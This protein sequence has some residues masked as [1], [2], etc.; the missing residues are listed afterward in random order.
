MDN[1]KSLIIVLLLVFSSLQLVS[2]HSESD[3]SQNTTETLVVSMPD[4]HTNAQGD[5]TINIEESNS[6][7]TTPGDP[8]L[9]TI[10]K[11]YT[12]PLGTT[13]DNID[14]LPKKGTTQ[15]LDGS[16]QPTPYP[17]EYSTTKTVTLP[18][19]YTKNIDSYS[20]KTTPQHLFSTILGA[21]QIENS[22]QTILSITYR[23]VSYDPNTQSLHI[24]TEAELRIDATLPTEKVI[25]PKEDY[26]LL[27]IT[28]STYTEDLRSLIDHKESVGIHTKLLTLATIE[29]YHYQGRDQTE[30]IKY[31][32]KDHVETY[33][34]HS[35]LLIGNIDAL[36]IR[37]TH[38]K[39]M[40][41]HIHQT[42][43]DLYYADLY[44]ADGTFS[45]WDTNQDD[46][47][48]E[49]GVDIV[50][51]YP[52]V[53]IGRLPVNNRAEL[54]TI[55][56]K[57]ISYE[58]ETYAE[59]WYH[60]IT[61]VG[62]DTFPGLLDFTNEGEDHNEL[63]MEVMTEFTARDIIWTSKDNFNKD[64][65]NAAINQGCGFVDYSGHGFEHGMGTYSPRR[66][67][68]LQ[69]YYTP[70]IHD[71]QNDRKLPV[72]FF[73]AC[74]TA[75]LDFTLQDMIN[76]DVFRP[77][78]LTTRH[79]LISAD[80][81]LDPYASAFLKHPN[82]GAIATIGATRTAFGGPSFGCEKLSLDF[83]K[84]YNTSTTLGEMFL[85]A[86]ITYRNDLPD[87]EFTI[88]EF[89]ILGDPTLRLGGYP[90]TN[91]D[92]TTSPSTPL[93]SF[94]NPTKGYTYNKGVA[95]HT[96]HIYFYFLSDAI[97]LGDFSA[98]N[99]LEIK[100]TDDL[101][102]QEDLEVSLRIDDNPPLGLP[103][104]SSRQSYTYSGTIPFGLHT[105]TATVTD[106]DGRSD[107]TSATML[108]LL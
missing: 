34:I 4:L 28:P 64:T 82:G 103:Y 53:Q 57:I 94:K 56:D 8:Q 90:S 17:Q 104:D 39:I 63:V 6:Y 86:Q 9:P 80:M 41:F 48:S 25:Q 24:I 31:A 23:P 98:S 102:T 100:A 73:D 79:Q 84:S 43:S 18:K 85:Q 71:L 97:L 78:H 68:Q 30:Q 54:N 44:N 35:V 93:I 74:L 50:D 33:N 45:S 19:P 55:I 101:T 13:I 1:I 2:A 108:R 61:Y 27:I 77:L 26:D 38:V 52:D 12:Y 89:L 65:I 106:T 67:R 88:E 69:T 11:T 49:S 58:T 5:L 66:E 10:T 96:I 105:Y 60:T 91:L 83:Y 75:K 47:F 37:T 20:T 3:L 22:I 7:T 51:L 76:Y 62:G 92:P 15:Q 70:Y 21:G 99:P 87:D 107:S 14:I 29:S 40:N 16:I 59:D 81:P 95:Q 46:K 42:L 72:I 36:P 32:I